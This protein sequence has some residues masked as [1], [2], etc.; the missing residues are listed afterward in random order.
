MRS[1]TGHSIRF[2]DLARFSCFPNEIQLIDSRTDE[3]QGCAR[4]SKPRLPMGAKNF[5]LEVVFLLVLSRRKPRSKKRK[6]DPTKFETSRSWCP[7]QVDEYY[8]HRIQ[9]VLK[10]AA[11]TFCVECA[12]TS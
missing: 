11:K 8:C 3:F 4:K 9:P 2:L 6:P 10:A 12:R 5:A 7:V 1:A